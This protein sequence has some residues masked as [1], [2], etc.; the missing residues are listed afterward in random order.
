VHLKKR[1]GRSFGSDV[2]CSGNDMGT[3]NLPSG[4]LKNDFGEADEAMFQ[5]IYRPSGLILCIVGIKKATCTKSRKWC[6]KKANAPVTSYS[7]LWTS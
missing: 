5:G 4:C 1:L 7:A 2:S 3:F 6:F